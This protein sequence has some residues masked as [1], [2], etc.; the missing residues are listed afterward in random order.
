M[1]ILRGISFVFGTIV[2]AIPSKLNSLLAVDFTEFG[3]GAAL[4]LA[5][6]TV[7]V[8]Q[9]VETAPEADFL[10]AVGGVHQ[11]AGSIAQT[12]VDDI[13]REAL[14]GMLA[15]E[16][17]ERGRCHACYVGKSGQTYLVMIVLVDILLDLQHLAAVALDNDPGIG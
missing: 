3:R 8:A 2:G 1:L 15:E 4:A 7:E 13:L 16:A 6:D 5:E 10:D 11:L 12:D 9:V 17:G 14:A